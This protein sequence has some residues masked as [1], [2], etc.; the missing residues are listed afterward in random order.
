MASRS[1]APSGTPAGS[2]PLFGR[3]RR[4]GAALDEA[5]RAVEDLARE[6]HDTMTFFDQVAALR[7]LTKQVRAVAGVECGFAAPME[8]S[9]LVVIRHAQ[10]LQ[11][12]GLIGLEIPAGRGLG[13]LAVA[14][15][16]PARVVDYGLDR[17]ITHDFDRPV[18]AEGLQG[19]FAVPLIYSGT[20]RGVV[21][22]AMHQPGEF[23]DRIVREVV[24]LSNATAMRLHLAEQAEAQSQIALHAERRRV[25][26]DLHDSLGATLFNIGAMVRNMRE[27]CP[28][29]P[30]QNPA[31]DMSS[32][33]SALEGQ[34]SEATA[35]LRASLSALYQMDSPRDLGL[36][37]QSDVDAFRELAAI[38]ARLLVL[39]EIPPL[40]QGA[41]DAL[42][43]VCREGLLNV[44]KHAHASTVVVT[45]ANLDDGVVLTVQDDGVGIPDGDRTGGHGLGLASNTDRIGRLGGSM[46]VS[47]EGDGTTLRAWLPSGN[48]SVRR[49]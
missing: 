12:E 1:G 7:D 4:S 17:S 44:R 19:C 2:P 13:G 9:G 29:D 23:G 22:G 6:L 32:K 28:P 35:T 34:I 37:L 27:L 45:L 25:A 36:S 26:A 11:E 14:E 43:A 33:L 48:S 24:Q 42:V 20:V 16:R 41:T 46:T 47:S 5:G 10:G 40:D 39:T 31:T 18:L 38:P 8:R 49:S 21:W 30:P 3:G 15:R